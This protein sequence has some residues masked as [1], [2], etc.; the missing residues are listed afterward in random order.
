YYSQ[1]FA[2]MYYFMQLSRGKAAINYMKE[3]KKTGDAEAANAK[4]FGKKMKNLK[5]IESHWKGYVRRLDTR[6]T[7][8]KKK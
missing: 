1:S 7:G 8:A 6:Q 5:K 2:V 3:L 4:L